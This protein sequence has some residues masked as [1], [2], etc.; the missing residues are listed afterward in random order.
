M[1]VNGDGERRGQRD[2]PDRRRRPDPGAQAHGHDIRGAP[3][4]REQTQRGGGAGVSHLRLQ[5]LRVLRMAQLLVVTIGLPV[6]LFPLRPSRWSSGSAG[7]GS[8]S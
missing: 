6:V 8:C 2:V 7:T 3:G 4:N 1:Q 5:I